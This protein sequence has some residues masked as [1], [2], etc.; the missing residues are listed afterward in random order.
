M[1]NKYMKKERKNKFYLVISLFMFILMSLYLAYADSCNDPNKIITYS[2]ND[3]EAGVPFNLTFIDM[4]NENGII[5]LYLPSQINIIN[6]NNLTNLTPYGN[7]AGYYT[8][9][10]NS[11]AGG[12]YNIT[13]EV[14][15]QDPNCNVTREIEIKPYEDEPNL[16]INFYIPQYIIAETSNL[17]ILNIKNIGN[18]NAY[19]I[20]GRIY[21]DN[22][23]NIIKNIN[24]NNLNKSEERNES[25]NIINRYC[26]SHTLIATLNYK[27]NVGNN[28]FSQNNTNIEIKGAKLEILAKFYEGNNELQ[29]GERVDEG[30]LIT[31]KA[32]ITN[33][34]DYPA[35]NS[36]IFIYEKGKLKKIIEIGN[37]SINEKRY[38]E[39]NFRL[40]EKDNV[41]LKAIIDSN[42]DCENN[43]Y[44][45]IYAIN[46][47]VISEAAGG[48]GGGAG[49]ETNQ[50]N[51]TYICGNGI[52]EINLGEN[53]TNC[54]QDCTSHIYTPKQPREN[55]IEIISDDKLV[56]L[57]INVRTVIKDK[58]GNRINWSEIK[59]TRIKDI[60]IIPT[61]P[62]N[63][64]L[65]RSYK[66]LPEVTFDLP[67]ELIFSYGD[68]I[69]PDANLFI[70]K[71]VGDWQELKVN[72]DKENKKITSQ[73][74]STSIFGLFTDKIKSPT[75]TGAA[76]GIIYWLKTNWWIPLVIFLFILALIIIFILS[77]QIKKL[78]EIKK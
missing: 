5:Y 67:A 21:L 75:I 53:S 38:I 17:A 43:P 54:P 24:I 36:K 72:W 41:E 35:L 46:I 68:E 13:V 19:N 66:I 44:S 22:F 25:F 34:G 61:W 4:F 62:N 9:T 77:I 31:L 6:G 78:K 73:I 52:C 33:K 20:N 27:D 2:P 51:Q 26:A 30:S 18:G 55:Y 50:T 32:N 69:L 16:L 57:R 28:Y 1:I 59:I 74:Y 76:I 45:T 71:F 49:G 12:K 23:A 48:G 63:V 70:Y 58:N 7:G 56:V 60:A 29:N 14:R 10:L 64:Y 47:K 8:W 65:V 15:Y 11:S 42:D 37:L 3:L 40:S 39:E